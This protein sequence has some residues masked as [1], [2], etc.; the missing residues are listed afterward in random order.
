MLNKNKKCYQAKFKTVR[1]PASNMKKNIAEILF[2]EGYIK[3]YERNP[4]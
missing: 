1:Y 3:A 2:N 4:K